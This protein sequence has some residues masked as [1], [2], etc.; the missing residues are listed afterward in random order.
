MV[1]KSAAGA[2]GNL[3]GISLIV[4][5]VYGTWH[6]VDR[7]DKGWVMALVMPPVA[8]YYA[9]ESTWH[10]DGRSEVCG[11]LAQCGGALS[12]LGRTPHDYEECMRRTD[13]VL[14]GQSRSRQRAFERF[15]K[16]VKKMTCQ[17][18]AEMFQEKLGGDEVR[19]AFR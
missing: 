14:A 7:H 12:E 17:D 11:K 6:M 19:P 3:M 2:A 5:T 18:L 4:A 10:S 8:I 13:I 15:A 16:S 1:G 9:V